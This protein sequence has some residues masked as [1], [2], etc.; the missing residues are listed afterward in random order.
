MGP[1]KYN[2]QIFDKGAKLTQNK[3][4]LSKNHARTIEHSYEK[5]INLNTD[6]ILFKKINAKWII[7]L[8]VKSETVEHL[9]D[10]R[11]K[12]T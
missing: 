12:F 1:Y 4:N 7:D 2:Q 5:Q 10:N 11:R 3:Y 8:N 6:A 9:E